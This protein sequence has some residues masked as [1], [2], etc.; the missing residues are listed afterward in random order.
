MVGSKNERRALGQF[1]HTFHHDGIVGGR[2]ER[3]EAT[4]LLG[5]EKRA[6]D[7]RPPVGG[8]GG[9]A[10]ELGMQAQALQDAPCLCL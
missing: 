2:P 4:E 9:L 8:K 1:G 10:L 5:T 7:G 3:N 6:R